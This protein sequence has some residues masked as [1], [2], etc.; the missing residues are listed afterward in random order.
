M[1]ERIN[2]HL[3]HG[4]QIWTSSIVG[5]NRPSG[6]VHPPEMARETLQT[7]IDDGLVRSEGNYIVQLVWT[8]YTSTVL[9]FTVARPDQPPLEI[10]S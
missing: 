4:G 10:K 3:C 2:I 5:I 9:Y 6:D 7:A 8:D 1:L